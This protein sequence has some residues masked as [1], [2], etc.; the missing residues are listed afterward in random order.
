MDFLMK[1]L[2]AVIVMASLSLFYSGCGGG[3]SFDPG[4]PDELDGDWNLT[5]SITAKDGSFVNNI[6]QDFEIRG[7]HL[8]LDGS[9]ETWF[10]SYYAPYLNISF[11]K[12]VQDEDVV[13]CGNVITTAKVAV[14][15]FLIDAD[16]P[17]YD[18][19][20]TGLFETNSDCDGVKRVELNGVFT[21]KRK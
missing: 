15:T 16:E 20:A 14:M 2:L 1:Y 10:G 6:N 4:I 21:L 12:I 9:E 8:Y 3:S 13:G 7:N 17:D 18:G 5:G 19:S 11:D